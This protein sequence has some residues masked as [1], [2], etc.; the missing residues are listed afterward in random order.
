MAGKLIVLLVTVIGVGAIG[1]Q[2]ALQ[3]TAIGIRRRQLI[4]FDYVDETIITTQGC[5]VADIG[6]P[7]VSAMARSIREI[8]GSRILPLSVRAEDICGMDGDVF[9]SVPCVIGREGVQQRLMPDLDADERMLLRQS[10]E[11]IGDAIRMTERLSSRS[12]FAVLT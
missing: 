3:L 11:T 2:V 9:L 12:Q 8:D 6:V 5:L 7:N 10:A 4:D 1:R